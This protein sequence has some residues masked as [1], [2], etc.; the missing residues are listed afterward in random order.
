MYECLILKYE[1]VADIFETL[2]LTLQTHT[3]LLLYENIL[4]NLHR[5]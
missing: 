4:K 1:I 5:N 2:I 3:F